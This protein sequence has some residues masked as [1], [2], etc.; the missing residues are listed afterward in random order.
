[1]RLIISHQI[2]DWQLAICIYVCIHERALLR[3]SNTKVTIF[4]YYM[5]SFEHHMSTLVVFSIYVQFWPSLWIRITSHQLGTLLILF[6]DHLCIQT[7]QL[8]NTLVYAQLFFDGTCNVCIARVRITIHAPTCAGSN[9][10]RPNQLC[11]FSSTSHA[12]WWYVTWSSD[13]SALNGSSES[14]SLSV[15]NAASVATSRIGFAIRQRRLFS[16]ERFYWV[17]VSML[18]TVLWVVGFQ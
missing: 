8:C 3:H 5:T 18:L 2:I 16:V 7:R 12:W 11:R 14:R 10:T 15:I 17:F 13:K 9:N 1:M 4:Y 6:W